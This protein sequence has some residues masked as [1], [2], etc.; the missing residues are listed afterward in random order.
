MDNASDMC[1]IGASSAPS[2]PSAIDGVIKTGS[3]AITALSAARRTRHLIF[4]I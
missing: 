4:Q 2:A 1:V 3:I